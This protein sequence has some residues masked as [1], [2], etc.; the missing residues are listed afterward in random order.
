MALN[1]AIVEWGTRKRVKLWR[2]KRREIAS[3]RSY[4]LVYAAEMAAS[5]LRRGGQSEEELEGECEEEDEKKEG[6]K[7]LTLQQVVEGSS[8]SDA[9]FLRTRTFCCSVQRQT[10]QVSGRNQD[11]TETHF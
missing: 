8:I 4:A 5:A 3:H 1:L 6:R 9:G 2:N 11:G 7:A 10:D